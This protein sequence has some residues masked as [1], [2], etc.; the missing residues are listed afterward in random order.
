LSALRLLC[1][2]PHSSRVDFAASRF[3]VATGLGLN[4]NGRRLER[5]DL[6]PQGEVSADALRREYEPPLR[7]L[8]LLEYALTDPDLR[9]ACASRG[10]IP[11]EGNKTLGEAAPPNPALTPTQVV[12]TSPSDPMDL[13]TRRSVER[14]RL[15]GM[16]GRELVMLCKDAGVSIYGSKDQLRERLLER[17]K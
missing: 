8:E 11:E 7:R 17:L 12:K 6:V 15:E 3:V 2:R 13:Q 5:G 16:S 10:V 1:D 4:I 9:E 14:L